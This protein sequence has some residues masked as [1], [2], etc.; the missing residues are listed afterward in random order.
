MQISAI[1]QRVADFLKGFPPFCYLDLPALDR[2]TEGGRVLFREAGDL[3]FEEGA[4]RGRFI[5]VIQ[6]GGVKFSYRSATGDALADLRGVG[7]IFGIGW[8]PIYNRSTHAIEDTILYALD[9]AAFHRECEANPHAARYVSILLMAKPADADGVLGGGADINWF[10]EPAPRFE[11]GSPSLLTCPPELT[12]REA[13]AQMRRVEDAA[14][15]IVDDARHPLGICTNFD[16]CS[17]VAIGDVAVDAPVRD[18]MQSPVFTIPPGLSVGDGLLE[19]MRR[20]ARHLCVTEDGTASTPVVDMLSEHVLMLFYG[21]NPLTLL[22]AVNSAGDEQAL[23]ALRE[24]LEVILQL[25]LRSFVDVDWFCNIVAEIDRGVIRKA[26]SLVRQR[27]GSSSAGG[28]SLL[29]LGTAGRR[30]KLARTGISLAAI[31]PSSSA[32]E[33]EEGRRFLGEVI[34]MLDRCGYSPRLPRGDAPVFC[35]SLERWETLFREWVLLP[36]QSDIHTRLAL[37]DF[38]PLQPGC[39]LALRLREVVRAALAEDPA[40]ATVLIND[41]VAHQPPLTFFEGN[42]MDDQGRPIGVL[43]I[44]DLAFWAASDV[45]RGLAFEAGHLAALSTMSRLE[46][47]RERYPAE[48]DLLSAAARAVRIILFLRARNAFATGGDGSVFSPSAI[49]LADQALLKFSFRAITKLLDFVNRRHGL[50]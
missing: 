13:A 45:A 10:R 38:D 20:G 46:K 43:D 27:L 49:P 12:V 17:R 7:E 22:R 6:Q 19:M 47:C 42:A 4:P 8:T 2:L 44:N 37:L 40:F 36:V 33:E 9:R 35:H 41:A 32:S 30:E 50:A 39:P 3:I 31:V 48:A 25:G 24:R 18:L 14:I 11:Q 5:Y 16:L 23:A 34:A 28:V 21:N 15:V 26:A 1:R 29:L